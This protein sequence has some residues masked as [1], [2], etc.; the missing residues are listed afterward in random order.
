[1][2]IQSATPIDDSGTL[3]GRGPTATR[4]ASRAVK[5]AQERRAESVRQPAFLERVVRPHLPATATGGEGRWETE[6]I[7]LDGTGAATVRVTLDSCPS[8]FAK[9][10]PGHDG[11]AVYDKLRTFRAAGFGAGS[12]YQA[13]EPL[14]WYPEAD[15]LLC[16][17]AEGRAVADLFDED[18]AAWR[19]GV[20]EA[21]TWLGTFHASGLA[22]GRPKSLLVTG[23]LLSLAKRLSKVVVAHPEHLETALGMIEALDELTRDTVEGVLVQSHGQYR[24]IHVFVAPSTFTVIDL[25]RSSPAD[26]ARDVAEFVHR[27]RIGVHGRTGSTARADGPTGDFLEAYARAAGA[28]RYL[29]NLRFHWARYIAHSLNRKVKTGTAQSGGTGEY[30]LYREEFDRVVSGRAGA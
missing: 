13:V 26:P 30:D 8:V 14:G 11:P 6:V 22:I 29:A 15:M 19:A 10:F 18:E 24:P 20:V 21:G 12:R 5:A 9:V 16:R 1:V 27:L 17:G 2:H 3:A 23:E 4:V 28:E 7:Q 25:D